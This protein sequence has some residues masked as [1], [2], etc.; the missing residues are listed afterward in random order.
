MISITELALMTA[1]LAAPRLGDYSALEPS[2][3]NFA[4]WI[5]FVLP[6]ADEVR[7]EEIPW[8]TTFGEG[9]QA[10]SDQQKSLL[11]W[12]MNGHPLGCT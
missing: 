3:E 10:A 7:H 2:E 1:A 9:L 12:G 11:F 4:R 8:S 6:S 5:E